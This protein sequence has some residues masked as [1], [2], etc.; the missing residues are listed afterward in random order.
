MLHEEVI[1]VHC[2]AQATTINNVCGKALMLVQMAE[3]KTTTLNK[4]SLKR[5]KLF[6]FVTKSPY[7]NVWGSEIVVT[8]IPN[9]GSRRT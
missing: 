6:I 4:V 7:E 2:E 1:A 9:L 5:A 3:P 8:R